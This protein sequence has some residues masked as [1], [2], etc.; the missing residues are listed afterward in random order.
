MEHGVKPAFMLLNRV[1]VGCIVNVSEI[2]N[3]FVFNAK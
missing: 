1:A 3:A 2:H